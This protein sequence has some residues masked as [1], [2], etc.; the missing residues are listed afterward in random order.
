MKLLLLEKKTTAKANNL[1]LEEMISPERFKTSSNIN[2]TGICSNYMSFGSDVQPL[3][4]T[5]IA[6]IVIVAA[7]MT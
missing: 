2:S 7:M 3:K 5:P 1:V 4:L 6:A